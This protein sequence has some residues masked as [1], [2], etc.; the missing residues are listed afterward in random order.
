[1]QLQRQ[2]EVAKAASDKSERTVLEC[3]ARIQQM[4]AQHDQA[5]RQQEQQQEQQAK[6]S[7]S[8]AQERVQALMKQVEEVEGQLLEKERQSASALSKLQ[9]EIRL[10]NSAQVAAEGQVHTL[11]LRNKQL[12]MQLQRQTELVLETRGQVEIVERRLIE[13]SRSHSDCQ[14]KLMSASLELQAANQRAADL[15]LAAQR[16]CCFSYCFS[17]CAAYPKVPLNAV[18]GDIELDDLLQLKE[19][20]LSVSVSV[21]DRQQ[22]DLEASV[23]L[24]LNA[25][26]RACF[27]FSW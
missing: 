15:Q 14:E 1:M 21:I 18:A 5:M 3:Q 4:Q 8:S 27:C 13:L 7:L 12:D 2:T 17:V 11:T 9:E 6:T 24:V 22:K 10:S 16:A 25:S 26:A 20:E 19:T 23:D